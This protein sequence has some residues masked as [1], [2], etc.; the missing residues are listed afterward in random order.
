MLS[1]YSLS[2]SQ[3]LYFSSTAELPVFLAS[4]KFPKEHHRTPQPI[5][6]ILHGV[7]EDERASAHLDLRD[8]FCLSLDCLCIL[9]GLHTFLGLSS[10]LESR[11]L[12]ISVE[13]ESE[14]GFGTLLRKSSLEFLS[15]RILQE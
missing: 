5:H 12:V 1:R 8:S 14:K 6:D 2:K 3:H 4:G 11:C 13:V 7:T 10:S 15:S 9:L